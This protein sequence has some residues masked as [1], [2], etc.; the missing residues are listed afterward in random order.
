[1]SVKTYLNGVAPNRLATS[2]TLEQ[3][4][5]REAGSSIPV[6][7]ST[8]SST[9]II[10]R[11][12]IERSP[13]GTS[14]TKIAIIGYSGRFPEAENNEEFW[15]LFMAGLDVVKEIPKDRFDPA[16][17][18]D[19]TGKKRNT[20][21]VTKGCFV[22]NPDLF[23]SRFF[24]MSPREAEQADP[25]QRLALMTAYEAMEMAGFVPDSTPSTQRNRIGVFY[26]IASDD[27]REVNAGQ[28]ID[29]Y[30]VPGGSRAFLPARI[31]YHFRFSG[32]SFDVDTACSSGLAAVH[33]ACN[34]LW[35]GDC[36]VAIA[37]GTNILTN[38]DNWA[39]LDRA[40]FLSRTGNCKTFDDGADG[41]CRAESVATVLL[42]RLD[43]AILDGDPIQGV[44]LGAL[45]NHSAEAVS[46]TRPHSGAQRAIFGRIL[47]SADVDSS[48]VSYVEMHGTGTQHGDACEMDS[49][50]NVF[51][52][53]GSRREKSLYLGS[54][55][56]NIGHA[57][58]ASGITSL[59]KVLLMMEKN[60]IPRHVGIK[61]NINRNFPTDLD[62]RNVHIAMQTTP[63]P[64]PNNTIYGRR[65][66]VNDFGAAGGNSSVLLEDAP[67]RQQL[68]SVQDP[69]PLYVVTVSA[70]FQAALKRNICALVNYLDA[71]PGT[72]LGSLSYTTTARCVYYN[73][74]VAGAQYIGMGRRL[75]E[76]P[77]FRSFIVDLDEVVRLCAVP[78]EMLPPATVQLAMTCFISPKLV[79]GYSLGEYAAM[80]VAGILSDTDTIYLVGTYTMLAVKAPVSRLAS[81]ITSRPGLEI[82]CANGPEETTVGGPNTEIEAF[83]AS[84]SS[85]S[86]KAIYCDSIT[87]KDPA[88]PLLSLLLGRVVTSAAD[89]GA[90][91]VYLSCYCRETSAG[92]ITNKMVWVEIGPYSTCSRSIKSILEPSPSRTLPTLRRSEDNWAVMVPTLTLLYEWGLAINWDDYYSGFNYWIPYA[93]D[94]LLTKGLPPVPPPPKKEPLT[95][96]VQDLLEESYATDEAWI[97]VR[98]DTYNPH[99]EAVLKGYRVNGQPVCSSAVYADM[100]LTLFSRLLEKFPVSFNKASMGIEAQNL[101]ADKSLILNNEAEQ[102]VEMKAYI[103]IDSRIGIP[104][105]NYAKCTSTYLPTKAWKTEWK[106]LAYLSVDDDDSGLFSLLVDYEPSFRGCR[107]LI[108]RSVDFESTAK[109]KFNTPEGT[110]DR[111]LFPPYWLD[112]L[113]QITGFTMN[114]NETLDSKANVYINRG[115][116]NMRVSEKLSPDI[117]YRTYV[118][119]QDNGDRSYM[120]DVYIFNPVSDTIIAAYE[121]VTFSAVPRKVLDKVLPRPSAA[122]APKPSTTAGSAPPQRTG[123]VVVKP[124]VVFQP[125]ASKKA[126]LPPPPVVAAPV[127]VPAAPPVSM[128]SNKIRNMVA[129]EVG[130]PISDVV[131]SAELADLGVDSLLALTMADRILEEL[132]I[133]VDSTPAP[134][135]VEQ[136]R[137]P[138]PPV[139]PVQP[140]PAAATASHSATADKLRV[141]IAE[142]VGAPVAEV[143]DDIDIADLGVDSLLS[144]TIAD[145][146]LEELG[147]KVDSTLFIAGLKIQDLIQ[148]VIGGDSGGTDPISS[149]HSSSALSSPGT[150]SIRDDDDDD[151]EPTAPHHHRSGTDTPPSSRPASPALSTDSG[152]FF[153]RSPPSP[154]PITNTH[155]PPPHRTLWLFPDG[156]GLAISYLQLPDPSPP[157]GNT[158]IAVYGLNSPFLRAAHHRLPDRDAAAAAA[159]ALPGRGLVGGWSAGG[160]CAYRAAQRLVEEEGEVVEGL[161]LIDSPEPMGRKKLPGRLYEEFIRRDVF[162]MGSGRKPPGWLLGHFMG[163]SNM[164]DTTWMVWAADG[165]DEEGTIEIR[166]EDPRNMRW[167]LG[168]RAGEDLATNGWEYLVGREG[169]E[170]EIVKGANHFSLMQKPAVTKMG[171]FLS[172]A[173]SS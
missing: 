171:A 25:A 147:V 38:P 150:R 85:M 167:L 168:T 98:S 104:T 5:K 72:Y 19:P 67:Q 88:I 109:V 29:T 79:V 14:M 49:V 50:L 11:G 70:K 125:P 17:Y 114:A 108:M 152:C 23:D 71:N 62:Q 36:D 45:T 106:R 148:I 90:L 15:D 172:R 129:E 149:S 66:F 110:A 99:F 34:S 24:G 68:A 35:T 121:G 169:I 87:F 55:K 53:D 16:L 118:K 156:S 151:Y 164:L 57:E 170:V 69:R 81:I 7:S 44:I 133:K 92:I 64:K 157:T 2:A 61:T 56:A 91:S 142:E 141:I 65:A 100:V 134:V 123:P 95:T 112:S 97:I 154:R 132:G 40:H 166:A 52:P 158:P 103:Y 105:A 41:Y 86:I 33:I 74:R 93:H 165:V 58:S 47:D 37:G 30:F 162:G 113:G 76:I 31:N 27:Y 20:S 32:P 78:L 22:K 39:G 161:A 48:D 117:T 60:Q 42:K 160:I 127:P 153:N 159:R 59:I 155:H 119:M 122:G 126:V 43:D 96:L 130:A 3:S 75:F 102:L 8:I 13:K 46:I 143:V 140:Q 1:M 73:F 26:G 21:G 137:V 135:P 136:P 83:A 82:C 173:V 145:R 107:E 80:N 131:D 28:N 116:E 120:G 54:A 77:R 101:V 18:C 63:W 89:L 9:L 94:W 128:T 139:Q 144:L 138:A 4:R 10:A 12:F 163:F 146:L 6:C 115:W 84:L 124:P 51:A 111:W